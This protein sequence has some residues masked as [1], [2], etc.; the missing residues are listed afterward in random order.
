MVDKA[1]AGKARKS[2]EKQDKMSGDQMKYGEGVGGVEK[3]A[4]VFIF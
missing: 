3:Q 1:A 4:V 2:V